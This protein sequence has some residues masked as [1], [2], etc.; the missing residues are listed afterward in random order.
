D[1]YILS[2]SAA[3]G[4]AI[5]LMDQVRLEARYT[6]AS[7]LQNSMSLQDGSISGTLNNIL[8]TTSIYSLGIDLDILGPQSAFQPFIYVGVGYVQTERS[9]YFLEDGAPSSI[10]IR[11]NPQTGI[12]AN[13][14]AGFRIK[15]VDAMFLEVEAFAYVINIHTPNPLVNLFG[16]AGIRLFF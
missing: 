15:V 13:G 12:S 9:Y 4:F 14:G 2:V 3:T 16:S 8:T 10:Y 5:G 11:E 6:N 1:S 7:S